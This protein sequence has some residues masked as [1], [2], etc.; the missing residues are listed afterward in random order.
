[1]ILFLTNGIAE[2]SRETRDISAPRAA[3]CTER[4][5]ISADRRDKEKRHRRKSRR[6]IVAPELT[7]RRS[8]FNFESTERDGSVFY[9]SPC[10]PDV[11]PSYCT[12]DEGGKFSG[13]ISSKR[14][15][16][17][18]RKDSQSTRGHRRPGIPSPE[19]QRFPETRPKGDYVCANTRGI[20]E[21]PL[22]SR[23]A[24][25]GRSEARQFR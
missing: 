15:E 25:L 16:T 9:R 11:G 21:R 20:R 2:R 22:S 23:T 14:R 7:G 19:D 10:P 12:Y 8:L 18:P 24:L 13:A 6:G 5:F 4:I 17:V 3:K 1:L